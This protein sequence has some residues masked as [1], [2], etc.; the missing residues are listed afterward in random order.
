[1]GISWQELTER[2]LDQGEESSLAPLTQMAV[3]LKKTSVEALSKL[4]AKEF[5]GK[6]FEDLWLAILLN[7][8]SDL[9]WE[10]KLARNL[11]DIARSLS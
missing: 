3:E 4:M 7:Y 1:M 10:E 8:R 11:F 5:L 2:S 9:Q 6:N